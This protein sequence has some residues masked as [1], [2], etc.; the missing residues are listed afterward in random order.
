MIDQI[1]ESEV[2]E[3]I[4]SNSDITNSTKVI[5]FND[6]W[7]SFDEVISQIMKATGKSLSEAEQLTLQVH[8]EGK[9]IVYD[10]DLS[11]CLK[12]SSILEEINL[13]TQIEY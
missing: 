13:H 7:H 10:G 9:A 8:N 4:L 11:N 2:L 6:E 12:V 1:T 3:D 5:L